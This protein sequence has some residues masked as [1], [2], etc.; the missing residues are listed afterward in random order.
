MKTVAVLVA[1][2][3]GEKYIVEQ[4]ESIIA[5]KGV[6]VNIFVRDDGSSDSTTYILDQYKRKGLLKWYYNG[7]KGIQK[8]FLDLCKHAPEA[9]YYAFCDQDD[10]WDEDKLNIAVQSLS[11]VQNTKPQIYYCG[12]RITDE[13]LNILSVHR[14]SNK[15]NAHTNFLVSNIAGCTAVFNRKLLLA[16]N[17]CSPDYIL[18]HDSW[19]F[20][21]C[22]S[23]GGVYIAD[24]EPH[25]NYR[26]HGD[27]SVGLRNGVRNKFRQ[28]KRYL[29]DF[30]IQKQIRSLYDCYSNQMTDDYLILSRKICNYDYSFRDWL[31]LLTSREFNFGSL[32]LNLIVRIKILLKKL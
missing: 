6:N 27:N 26:Q 3:N 19:V 11:Q 31:Y 13:N 9:D 32:S 17:N 12:Q 8:G 15:R 20:K 4:L 21:I 29:N 18:M 23:I 2:Y 7:H 25:I 22:I 28:A 30:K 16:V 1:T 14:I 24:P 5:Q 10:V